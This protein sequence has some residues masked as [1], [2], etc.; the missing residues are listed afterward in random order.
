MTTIPAAVDFDAIRLQDA[1]ADMLANILRCH[2][3]I[4]APLSERIDEF[5]RVAD[6]L[7]VDLWNRMDWTHTKAP[8]HRADMISPQWCRVVVIEADGKRSSVY[9][10]IALLDNFTK[11]LG[12]IRR[13]DIH[14]PASW[15]APAKHA[16]GNVHKADFAKCLTHYG[17]V[18]LR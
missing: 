10:F 18:Y 16:R 6:A 9:A 8:T 11:T 7:S 2:S 3:P 5:V 4:E 17:P 1:E 14:K 13:G 15:K 12:T